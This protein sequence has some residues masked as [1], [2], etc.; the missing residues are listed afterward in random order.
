MESR[1]GEACEVW[2]FGCRNLRP[3]GVGRRG[4][5]EAGVSVVMY[6]V[7]EYERRRAA[8]S[9][10][11]EA[12]GEAGDD[13]SAGG[14]VSYADLSNDGGSQEDEPAIFTTEGSRI[15]RKKRKKIFKTSSIGSRAEGSAVQGSPLALQG[16]CRGPGVGDLA[17]FVCAFRSSGRSGEPVHMLICGCAGFVGG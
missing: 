1:R 3:H 15:S 6:G 13:A 2:C 11:A 16:G 8:A 4:Q 14:D 9:A 12:L 7:Q 17:V 5:S 10:E